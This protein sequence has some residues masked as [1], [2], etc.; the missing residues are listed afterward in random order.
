MSIVRAATAYQYV[1]DTL[2]RRIVQGEYA[3]GERLPSERE[4]CEQFES[5]RITIRRALDIL[6]DEMLIQR[7]Q[8]DGTYVSPKPSRKIPLLSTDFSGSLAAH[9]PDLE[10]ELGASGWQK[11]SADVAATLQT[12]P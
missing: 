10:R 5:S 11:A 3:S 7:R 2:R 12:Y 8:G 4:L 1:A 9:A 6:A